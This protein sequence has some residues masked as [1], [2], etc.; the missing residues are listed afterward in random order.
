MGLQR[1]PARFW[2]FFQF[3]NSDPGFML[4]ER[5]LVSKFCCFWTPGRLDS[6]SAAQSNA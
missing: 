4:G 3:V 2:Y 5:S 1:L 6:K